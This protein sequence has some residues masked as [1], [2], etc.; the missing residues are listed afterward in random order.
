MFIINLTIR[1]IYC[2]V[3][4]LYDQD[5]L[6]VD[7]MESYEIYVKFMIVMDTIIQ[8]FITVINDAS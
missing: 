6:L 8:F 4:I 2:L 7:M 1:L 5:S 3:T